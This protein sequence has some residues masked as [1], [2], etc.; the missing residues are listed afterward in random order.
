MQIKKEIENVLEFNENENIKYQHLLQ[1]I[2]N[3]N[4]SLRAQGTSKKRKQKDCEDSGGHRGHQKTSLNQRVQSHTSSQRLRQCPLS[5]HRSAPNP[6]CAYSGFQFNVFFFLL[7][8]ECVKEAY[9][10]FLFQSIPKRQFLKKTFIL[11][12]IIL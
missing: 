7:N 9:L 6:L 5:L 3:I 4:P 1:T 8:P 12:C 2:L 11:Y 10:C